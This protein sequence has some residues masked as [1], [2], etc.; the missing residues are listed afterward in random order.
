MRWCSL[1]GYF[2]AV[3]GT[4]GLVSLCRLGGHINGC[5]CKREEFAAKA[6]RN[7]PLEAGESMRISSGA[8]KCLV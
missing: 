2:L 5:L 8:Y 3:N 7:N 4:D 6:G 1:S